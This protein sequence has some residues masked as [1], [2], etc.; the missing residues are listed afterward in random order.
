[1]V[2]W[3]S[4]VPQLLRRCI[5]GSQRPT[6]V[7]IKSWHSRKWCD[8]IPRPVKNQ[9]SF[10]QDPHDSSRRAIIFGFESSCEVLVTAKG[11]LEGEK[12]CWS[13]LKWLLD[14]CNV[15]MFNELRCSQQ[16]HSIRLAS[17]L[18]NS[19]QTLKSFF[20]AFHTFIAGKLQQFLSIIHAAR[21]SVICNCNIWRGWTLSLKLLG[22][23]Y[24]MHIFVDICEKGRQWSL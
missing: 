16:G 14:G 7:A 24:R 22:W 6:Y 2:R 9:G 17:W 1:M 20:Q 8:R 12:A 21:P 3:P 19:G 11:F 15:P 5:P 23:C 4:R 13:L 18:S 10:I